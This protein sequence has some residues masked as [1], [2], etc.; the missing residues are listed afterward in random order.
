MAS[1]SRDFEAVADQELLSAMTLQ[2]YRKYALRCSDCCDDH[3]LIE[4]AMDRGS[5]SI[6]HRQGCSRDTCVGSYACRWRAVSRPCPG[7]L[8]NMPD[9]DM[10]FVLHSAEVEYVRRRAK[11]CFWIFHLRVT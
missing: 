8:L 10:S 5:L 9:L 2:D 1:S 11:C 7:V 6:Y 3:L 4:M